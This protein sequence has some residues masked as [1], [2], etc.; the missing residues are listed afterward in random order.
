MQLVGMRHLN[1]AVRHLDTRKAECSHFSQESRHTILHHGKLHERAARRY[2]DI[3]IS[4]NLNLG[5]QALGT[6]QPGGAPAELNEI[7]VRSDVFQVILHVQLAHALIQNK[8]QP[9]DARLRHAVRQSNAAIESP[10]TEGLHIRSDDMS[11]VE[12]R[13]MLRGQSCHD[14]ILYILSP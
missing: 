13:G 1:G 8:R 7:N 10:L 12:T 14:D 11:C 5:A 2:P 6:K 3:I 9:L 4:Q